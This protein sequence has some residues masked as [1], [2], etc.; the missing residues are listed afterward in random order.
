MKPKKAMRTFDSYLIVR[1]ECPENDRGEPMEPNDNGENGYSV[2][3]RWTS[4]GGA[5][6]AHFQTYAET[7]S[8]AESASEEFGLPVID[9][10]H[11]PEAHPETD[12]VI[13]VMFFADNGFSSS[14]HGRITAKEWA[15]VAAMVD[16]PEMP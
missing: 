10:I 3:G 8:L 14:T 9:T 5:P 2:Y 4:G 1:G 12:G 6:L 13:V 15:G 16:L 7:R 11:P